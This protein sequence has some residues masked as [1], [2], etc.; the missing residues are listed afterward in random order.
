[1]IIKGQLPLLKTLLI[2]NILNS[3]IEL[4]YTFIE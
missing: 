1:M 3:K 4:I 2:I